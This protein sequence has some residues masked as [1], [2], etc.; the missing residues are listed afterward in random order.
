M[1]RNFSFLKKKISL[2]SNVKLAAAAALFCKLLEPEMSF[3]FMTNAAPTKRKF[4]SQEANDKKELKSMHNR[5]AR[6]FKRVQSLEHENKIF[7]K[8]LSKVTT[9]KN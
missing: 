2:D 3:A 6:Y 4:F 1:A 7:E 5:V 9:V 8:Q